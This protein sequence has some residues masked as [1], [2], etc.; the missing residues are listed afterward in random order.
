[1][2]GAQSIK[3]LSHRAIET[4][5]PKDK[6]KADTGENRGLRVT[7]GATGKKSFYYRYRSPI[8]DRLVQMQLG[9]FP[10]M[11]LEQAR[12]RLRELKQ[13]RHLGRCPASEAKAQHAIETR[14]IEQESV[15]IRFTVS[16]LVELYLAEYIE[17]R[18][19]P[20]GTVIK[21]AR[22]PKGQSE[23]RR[24]LYGDAVKV[25]GDKSA[26][27]VSRQN[28][29]DM[30]MAIVARGANVQAGNVLRELSACYEYAIGLGRF[31][32]NFINPAF[33]AKSSLKRT[34]VK[35]TSNKGDRVLDDNELTQL[36]KWLP[37]SGYSDPQKNVIRMTLWTGCRTGEICPA[38]WTDV[39]LD[40]GVYYIK[41]S[42]TDV[43]REVQ[44]PLQAVEFLK[45]LRLSTG[46]CLFPSVLTKKPI[47]QKLLTETAWHLREGNKMLDIAPWTPHDLRRT[48]RTGLAR[49][50]CPSDVAEAVL[51]HA[52]KGIEG[53]YNLHRYS[54]ECKRWLQVWADHMDSLTTG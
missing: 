42:K 32:D 28:I 7:C 40:K 31:D 33:Q 4:M 21:G 46:Y 2:T 12:I 14:Y 23:V 22:K 37:G 19:L 35:L 1:M 41:E 38:L 16:D 27:E 34:K 15:S 5:K 25:L 53:T 49:L 13:I 24:T 6:D 29:V 17:D 36:L 3:P 47:P 54:A 39:D 11:T 52:P 45:H 18:R 8:T 30:I 26:A 51:G 9:L 43:S 10:S 50:Q 44:L 48:V 20:N